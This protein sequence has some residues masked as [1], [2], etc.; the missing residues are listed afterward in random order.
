M[1]TREELL[2][3]FLMRIFS[4]I[5][6]LQISMRRTWQVQYLF[7]ILWSAFY[8][9]QLLA[10]LSIFPRNLVSRSYYACFHFR[11]IV[12]PVTNFPI[13][14]GI[15]SHCGPSLSTAICQAVTVSAGHLGLHWRS[16][17]ATSISKSLVVSWPYFGIW[18]K[19]IDFV[20]LLKEFLLS[21]IFLY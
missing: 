8:P 1:E 7:S 18:I 12:S 19:T 21:A 11:G 13:N 10:N 14:S 16:F 3:D 15:A 9:A 2:S 6:S 20:I 4:L 5:I 17:Y